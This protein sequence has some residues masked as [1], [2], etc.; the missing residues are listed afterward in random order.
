MRSI[1][2]RSETKRDHLRFQSLE[3]QKKTWYHVNHLLMHCFRF[4]TDKEIRETCCLINLHWNHCCF[5]YTKTYS[6]V[7]IMD[8][9]FQKPY[10]ELN[11]MVKCL[12]GLKRLHYIARPLEEMNSKCFQLFLTLLRQNSGL[13]EIGLEH[14]S[15][16]ERL[17]KI[18]HAAP[19]TLEECRLWMLNE[20]D[21]VSIAAPFFEWDNIATELS[22]QTCLTRF[23]FNYN[24]PHDTNVHKG[25]LLQKLS[26]YGSRLNTL[27]CKLGFFYVDWMTYISNAC[28]LLESLVIVPQ[29]SDIVARLSD[30]YVFFSSN[31]I[32]QLAV[33]C[34]CLQHVLLNGTLVFNNLDDWNCV[35]DRMYNAFA[36][37]KQLRFLG[38]PG[39]NYT[40]PKIIQLWKQLP[41]LSYLQCEYPPH[42]PN[43]SGITDI[44]LHLQKSHQIKGLFWKNIAN[45]VWPLEV[46]FSI[47]GMCPHLIVLD[48]PYNLTQ[49]DSIP[50]PKTLT[51]DATQFKSRYSQSVDATIQFI[52]NMLSDIASDDFIEDPLGSL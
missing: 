35:D 34:P 21:L 3:K 22:R 47:I 15:P 4:L 2:L 29:S 11:Q 8:R 42:Y 38:L 19:T 33:H 32:E 48:L 17:L 16:N 23:Y 30:N 10:R 24:Q 46:I 6:F 13:K 31:V 50:W 9:R 12:F 37:M 51:V 49:Q 18:L 20:T 5:E 44:P 27:Y 26:G 36:K 43:S 40:V 45:Y 28:P 39:R 7:R 25:Y 52:Y 14:V 41:H 1:K